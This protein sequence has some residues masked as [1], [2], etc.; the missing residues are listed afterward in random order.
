[1]TNNNIGKEKISM[2][3]T[4]NTNNLNVKVSEKNKK[5]MNQNFDSFDKYGIIYKGITMTPVRDKNNIIKRK[6]VN[7]VDCGIQKTFSAIYKYKN[8]TYEESSR[9][10]YNNNENGSIIF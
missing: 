4:Q 5:W 8:I 7:N 3:L 1:M 6:I 10:R 9:P 2:K